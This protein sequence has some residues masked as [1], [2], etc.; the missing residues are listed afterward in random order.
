MPVLLWHAGKDVFTPSAH[1][2]WLA[3]RI[4]GALTV[5]EPAAAHFAA[6]RALPDVLSWLLVA[7]EPA[8]A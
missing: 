1:S 5:Y 4:P 3:D 7:T 6:I 2:S 8:A